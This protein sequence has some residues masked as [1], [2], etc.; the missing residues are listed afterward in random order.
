MEP[1]TG[2]LFDH[3]TPDKE[4]ASPAVTCK[5]LNPSCGCPTT[6]VEKAQETDKPGTTCAF[7]ICAFAAWV[8]AVAA[9]L[10]V[11]QPN[12][13]DLPEANRGSG[14]DP[15]TDPVAYL[16]SK[17]ALGSHY[18]GRK[19]AL[20]GFYAFQHNPLD[21]GIT[22]VCVLYSAAHD[23]ADDPRIDNR[24]GY[25]TDPGLTRLER[26]FVAGFV[27]DPKGGTQ[28]SYSAER[29]NIRHLVCWTQEDLEALYTKILR[30]KLPH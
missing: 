24:A 9:R 12:E 6:P 23:P 8:R 29:V 18:S 28:L 25:K 13:A 22:L 15:E 3:G 20:P 5:T 4:P 19:L 14:P 16:L 1:Y 26:F 21:C 17:R 10:S 7:A 27:E 11:S 30:A 2:T